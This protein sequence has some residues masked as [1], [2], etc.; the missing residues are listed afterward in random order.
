MEFTRIS[1][2]INGNPRYVV[3]FLNFLSDE[4]LEKLSPLDKYDAALRKS[5][6]VGGKKYR[7]RWFGGGIVVSTYNK[8]TMKKDIQSIASKTTQL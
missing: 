1:N 8:P 3:H 5:R 7:A 2:D 6:A 4:E